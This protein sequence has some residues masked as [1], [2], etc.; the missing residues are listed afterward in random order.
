MAVV[1]D[2][3]QRSKDSLSG[4]FV[5]VLSEQEKKEHRRRS[6]A[7]YNRKRRDG[8]AGA[9]TQREWNLWHKYGLSLQD[10]ENL[11]AAQG[12]ACAICLRQFAAIEYRNKKTHKSVWHVDHDHTTGA[13]RGVLCFQC[14]SGLGKFRD[15]PEILR[16]GAAYLEKHTN[17]EAL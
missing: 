3:L 17:S 15:N 5:G 11:L 10:F 6:V 8:E 2:K 14:N 4:R 12:G 7:R 16:A 1:L 9:L 13:V